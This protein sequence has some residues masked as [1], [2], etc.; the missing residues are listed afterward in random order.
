[1]PEMKKALR[2]IQRD[3]MVDAVRKSIHDDL[4]VVREPSRT[5]RVQPSSA[6][7][8]FVRV[9]PVE[10]CHPRFDALGEQ[11]I[12]QSVIKA[13]PLAVDGACACG[14]HAWPGNGKAIR[15]DAD[16]AHQVDVLLVAMIVVASD[17][18]C[19]PFPDLSGLPRQHV[20]DGKSFLVFVPRA[21][22]LIR[23]RCN[24]PGEIA[25]KT[26]CIERGCVCC[27]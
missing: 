4:D 25:W 11:F 13:Q 26:H 7:K 27:L 23:G 5:V 15:V 22:D 24:A 17:V 3:P 18:A 10:K 1:M 21:F 2:F 16:L 14:K 6:E 8:K 12:D 19:V 9:V 20:P